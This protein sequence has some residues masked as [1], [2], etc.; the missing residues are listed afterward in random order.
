MHSAKLPD[1]SF[2]NYSMQT[3]QNQKQL[4]AKKPLSFMGVSDIFFRHLQSNV[5]SVHRGGTLSV[6]VTPRHSPALPARAASPCGAGE[7]RSR[8]EEL[9]S[10]LH[11]ASG[12]VLQQPLAC[13]G[14]EEPACPE[15]A[16]R[17]PEQST[18][19]AAPRLPKPAQRD[20]QQL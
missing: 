15:A 16:A 5:T 2:M 18:C 9:I 8:R 4:Q 17:S 6:P 13:R 19:T 12:R 11:W 20:P 10:L 3:S 7:Q 14:D 1:Y